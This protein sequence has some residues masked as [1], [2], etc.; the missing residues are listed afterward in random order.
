MKTHSALFAPAGDPPFL[1]GSASGLDVQTL[2]AITQISSLLGGNTRNLHANPL[3]AGDATKLS[4]LLSAHSSLLESQFNPASFL[5]RAQV[6]DFFVDQAEPVSIS[7]QHYRQIFGAD[8]V[9]FPESELLPQL[10]ARDKEMAAAIYGTTPAREA[11]IVLETAKA[12]NPRV[13]LVIGTHLGIQSADLLKQSSENTIVIS[14]DILPSWVGKSV[15]L[16]T[17]N[18][19]YINK[20]SLNDE[21]VGSKVAELPPEIRSRHF[22][23]FGD[24]QQV[25]RQGATLASALKGVCDLI[26]VDGDH[27]TQAATQDICSAMNLLSEGGVITVDDYMKPPRLLSVTTAVHNVAGAINGAMPKSMSTGFNRDFRPPVHIEDFQAWFIN[28]FDPTPPPTA[29]PS[30]IALITLPK[31]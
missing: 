20:V 14:L 26:V 22:Q 5:E 1:S 27:S 30:H 2:R 25:L 15:H 12:I 4:G 28:G 10:A 13:V 23:F 18:L 6:R 3:T 8:A 11:T 24:S 16:N 9:W 31:L 17:T 21:T 29:Q 19:D 7:K